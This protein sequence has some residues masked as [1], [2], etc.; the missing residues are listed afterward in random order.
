VPRYFVYILECV[1]GSL[2]TGYTTDPA[3]RFREHSNGTGSRYTRSRR[4]LKLS[5]LEERESRNDALRRE[6]R[7]KRM[8]RREK[9]SLCRRYRATSGR[10]LR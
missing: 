5:Y 8:N 2:Y 4:P 3:R 7:I 9:Q 6:I 1:D 10:S